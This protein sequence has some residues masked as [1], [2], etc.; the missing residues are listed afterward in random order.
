LYSSAAGQIG[1]TGQ[2]NYA[3]ANTFLDALA[4]HRHTHNQPATSIAWGLWNTTSQMT[5]HMDEDDIGRLGRNGMVPMSEEEGLALFDQALAGGAQTP[6]V[7]VALRTDP[8][9]LR[10]QA[11]AG[12]LPPMLRGLVRTTA[13]RG[14]SAATTSGSFTERLVGRSED[15][16]HALVMELVRNTVAAVLGHESPDSLDNDQSFKDLGFDSLTG[17]ELRNR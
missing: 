17:V 2:A 4:T 3:A 5:Q 15:E 7:L 6:P 1:N 12:V 10:A 8:A 16:Q 13:R 9:G 11:Q 14:E